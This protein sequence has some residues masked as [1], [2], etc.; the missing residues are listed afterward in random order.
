MKS[1]AALRIVSRPRLGRS[2]ASLASL[3]LRSAAMLALLVRG[4]AA[5]EFHG[6]GVHY[7]DGA[8]RSPLA[9][10]GSRGDYSSN[11]LAIDDEHSTVS[12]D[13]STHR[14]VLA[15]DHNYRSKTIVGDV[16]LLARGTTERGDEIPCAVHVKV[17]KR[18]TTFSVDVHPHPTSRD[19]LRN[20]QVEPY[21]IV[22]RGPKGDA[23]L[24]TPE[25]LRK[26]IEE[27]ELAARLAEIFVQAN[28][29]LAGQPISANRL[30]ARLV[31]VTIG[32]GF[33]KLNLKVG[34]FELISKDP[35]N[36]PLIRQASL[37]Q[38]IAR[39][40]WE[41]RITAMSW[42]P[43][44]EFTRDVFLFGLDAVP[45]LRRLERDGLRM[46]EALIIG[47]Q[48]GRGYVQFGSD[49]AEIAQPADVARAY[50]E[51]H[52]IGGIIARQVVDLPQRIGVSPAHR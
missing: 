24:A 2:R 25:R 46:G 47:F 3:L 45:F 5:D 31:D 36:E 15:N 34:R 42:L 39:G 6:R 41:L 22:A 16:V 49:R 35:M 14:I 43:P 21:T 48:N 12:I 52:F 28:D 50:L 13:V 18:G 10:I 29:Q 23:T 27:P 26:T 37:A 9:G 19:S 1:R 4:A 38:M 32:F 30:D 51:F 17:E 11:R 20:V 44:S 8:I 33:K 7:F 40:A